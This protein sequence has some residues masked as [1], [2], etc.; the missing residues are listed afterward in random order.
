MS[1]DLRKQLKKYK[2]NLKKAGL[3]KNKLI[4]IGVTTLLVGCSSTPPTKAAKELCSG[5]KKSY[6]I[7]GKAYH[8]QD[9]YD[10]D[11]DGVA[12]WY[13]PGFHERPTSCG[14]TYD[15]H[16]YTA[17]HKTLPIPSVVEVTN[18]ENGKN[19]KLVVNDRGPFVD[20]RI[21]DLSKK[22]A[23]ELGTHNKGLAR[24]RVRAIPDESQALAA[25]LKRYGRYGID[26][27][28]RK[29]DDIYFQEIAGR[30]PTEEVM[31]EDPVI[32]QAVLRSDSK[33][34]PALE[35]TVMRS[36]RAQPK[37]Q[38]LT[39]TQEDEIIFE[40]L[41]ADKSSFPHKKSTPSRPTVKTSNEGHFIQVGNFVQKNNADKLKQQLAK[42]GKTAVIKDKRSGNMYSIKLGPYPNRQL[43]QKK[44]NLVTNEG[45][46]GARLIMN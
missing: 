43:A 31:A 21:I 29:W 15:M 45:H 24:V 8:P 40:N 13:G 12:S 41:L 39:F 1:A 42:H 10:Y 30:T 35:R 2:L 19:L 25:Y 22:A 33:K 7:Q 32:T 14:S 20:D 26:P 38:N 27:S 17:A 36:D 37:V 5:T 4:I 9:H 23:I 46:H 11:E 28:G 44:L 34:Q 16:A 6:K 18:L 3:V